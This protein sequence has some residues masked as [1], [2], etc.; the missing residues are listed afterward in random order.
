MWEGHY[1]HNNKSVFVIIIAKY[2]PHAV[3]LQLSLV[4]GCTLSVYKAYNGRCR[5]CCVVCNA[6]NETKTIHLMLNKA[7]H[8]IININT[9]ILLQEICI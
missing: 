2:Q 8:A 1:A 6:C 5:V 9:I 4:D 7:L 3:S